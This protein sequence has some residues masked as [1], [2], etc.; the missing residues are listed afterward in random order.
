MAR[1]RPRVLLLSKKAVS[2]RPMARST[3]A[4]MYAHAAALMWRS[5]VTSPARRASG[6]R[7]QLPT[8]ERMMLSEKVLKR[9][10]RSRVT[11]DRR[12]H[13]S[14]LVRAATMPRAG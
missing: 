3:L 14:A 5:P 4:R 11:I 8:A 2:P 9:P 10:P 6:T 1:A 7:R 12:V 13:V